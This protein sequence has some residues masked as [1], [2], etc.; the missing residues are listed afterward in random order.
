MARA[1]LSRPKFLIIFISWWSIWTILQISLRPGVDLKALTA[2]DLGRNSE[3]DPLAGF[4]HACRRDLD[5][6][7]ASL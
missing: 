6:L 2:E 1:P 7:H 4:S 5:S 3:V